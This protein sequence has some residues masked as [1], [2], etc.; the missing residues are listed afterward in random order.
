MT[1]R[2]PRRLVAVAVDEIDAILPNERRIV[3][4]GSY[5]AAPR[6]ELIDTAGGIVRFPALQRSRLEATE[7]EAAHR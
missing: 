5:H 3:I 4:R 1:R 7:D 6:E 2:L